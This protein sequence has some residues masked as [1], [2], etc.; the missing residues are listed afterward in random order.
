MCAPAVAVI[1]R[2]STAKTVLALTVSI[3]LPP[4][5]RELLERI[6]IVSAIVTP[7]LADER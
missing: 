1:A 7:V 3:Y 4:K 5:G 2:A 6:S